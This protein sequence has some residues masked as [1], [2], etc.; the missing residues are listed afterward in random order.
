MELRALILG[1]SDLILY[2][3]HKCG[4][5]NTGYPEVNQLLQAPLA[6]SK[7]LLVEMH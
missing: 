2:I 3:F 1:Y 7:L 4:P 5:S 6:I